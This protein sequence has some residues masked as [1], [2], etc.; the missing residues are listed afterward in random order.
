MSVVD[1]IGVD[2]IT[3]DDWP[4]II[5]DRPLLV[6]LSGGKDSTATML[7]LHEQGLR[8]RCHYVF[9]D[10]GWEHPEVYRYLDEVVD[11][12]CGGRLVR[13]RSKKYP[14][15]M[16]QL[17]RERGLFPTRR[18][19][20]CTQ[21]LKQLPIR[22]HIKELRAAGHDVINT[23]GI[24]AAESKARSRFEMWDRGGPMGADVDVWRPLIH[25]TVADVIDIH[26]RHNVR[27]CSLYLRSE[28]PSLRVGC[29]P[30][31]HSRKAEVRAVAETDPGRI[32]VI[33]ELESDVQAVKRE[34][35]GDK[36]DPAINGA[37]PTFF[38]ARTGRTGEP[39]PI[40]KVV[41]WSRTAHGG[42]QRELFTTDTPGCQMWG[43]C[44][45]GEDEVSP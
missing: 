42:R 39:W 16:P 2:G 20:F 22:D 19:R 33:R 11:P 14:R 21:E 13:V 8:E 7:W 17:V 37:L 12:L 1:K 41:D 43:L 31:I 29:W 3:F 23:V 18:R 44:D 15:G 45:M 5:E 27:P 30:C 10:T 32:D 35:K 25:W 26:R 34:R 24:R 38:Q 4:R 36:F 40:D 28:H 6:S 9:A